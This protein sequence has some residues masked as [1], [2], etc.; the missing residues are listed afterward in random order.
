M[1]YKMLFSDYF[2]VDKTIISEYGAVNISLFADT[3]LFID[4]LLIFNNDNP[5][6]KCLYERISSYLK[7]LNKIAS[8]N[9]SEDEIQYYFRFKEVKENWLG[10]SKIGNCGNALGDAFA[11]EL[12]SSIGGV[13][14]DNGI[15]SDVHI[16]KMYLVKRGVGKD[17]ISDWT[18]NLLLGFLP[19]TQKGLQKNI[20][21]RRNVKS[22]KCANILL[23]MRL[24]NLLPKMF[25]FRLFQIKTEKMN[26]FF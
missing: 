23:I 6:I 13:C 16:E 20:L 19:T 10:V 12:V 8:K 4:P 22:S 11:N 17:K 25:I 9:P 1:A 21:S 5:E 26:M 3:P 14:D 2:N 7:F 15:T 18:M 24:N